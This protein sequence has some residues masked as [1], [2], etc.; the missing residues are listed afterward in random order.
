MEKSKNY[1]DRRE[2]E[3]FKVIDDVLAIF[4]SYSVQ[5]GQIINISKGGLALRYI[6]G[7]KRPKDRPSWLNLI[8]KG[9]PLS[10]DNKDEISISHAGKGLYLEKL[11]VIIISDEEISELANLMTLRQRSLKF[12]HL[13]HDQLFQLESLI[14]HYTKGLAQ[15]RRSGAERRTHN[16]PE[17]NDPEWEIRSNRRKRHERRQF[18]QSPISPP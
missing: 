17:Y 14:K 6:V 16:A 5:M 10:P 4:K 1:F 15:D 7:D 9:L 8:R 18:N 12:G 13:R 3:R 2:S 11:P